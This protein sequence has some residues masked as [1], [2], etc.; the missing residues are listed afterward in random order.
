[1]A[2]LD[3][4]RSA[5]VREHTSVADVPLLPTLHL[6]QATEAF[7]L[8]ETTER[9]LAAD[10]MSLPFWAFAWPGGV[11][12]AR[13]LLDHPQLVAGRRVLDI[14]SGSGLVAIAAARAGASSVI[15][16]DVDP[17]A[18]AA[19]ELNARINAVAVETLQGDLLADADHQVPLDSIEVALAG[20]L[21]YDRAM[22]E[23]IFTFLTG[24]AARGVLVYVG[25]PGRAHLPTTKLDRLASYRVPVNP[26]LELAGTKDVGIWRLTRPTQT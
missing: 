13:Y 21:A 3:P 9:D 5:F 14:G 22:S 25:D 19:I 4:S 11:A 17:L 1:M 6:H 2:A 7:M 12:L 23:R 16:N 10:G 26:A 15:A 24:L 18:L 20:D 8:S